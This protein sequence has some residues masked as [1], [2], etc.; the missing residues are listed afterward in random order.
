[1]AIFISVSIT[2][3]P[4]RRL[5][6]NVTVRRPPLVEPESDH[7]LVPADIR[8]LERFVPIHRKREMNGR[9]AI[10]L[11]QLM[12][13]TQLR[14]TFTERFTSL[15]PATDVD[16]MRMMFAEAML[17]S[18]ANIAPRAK[19]SQ[20]PAGWCASEQTKAEKVVAWQEREAARELLRADPS[21][22]NLRTPLKGAGKRLKPVRIEDVQS[23]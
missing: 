7:N 19:R 10:E 14:R 21:N 15:P 20:G 2:R 17:S 12:A 6:R 16:G 5:V 8:V 1:M 23:T 11:Q 9:R 4:D 3:K 22:S 13:N 18:A